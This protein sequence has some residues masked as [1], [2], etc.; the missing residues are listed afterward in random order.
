MKNDE[1]LKKRHR[2][3][4]AAEADAVEQEDVYKI[5]INAAVVEHFDDAIKLYL[6]EIQKS[7]LLTAHEERELAGKRQLNSIL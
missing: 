2:I 5:E 3:F 4:P 6:R 1:P 7:K